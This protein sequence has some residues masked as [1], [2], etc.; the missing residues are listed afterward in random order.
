MTD[1]IPGKDGSRTHIKS[2][3]MRES[4]MDKSLLAST[5]AEGV[6]RML[7]DVNVVAIGGRSILDRG[8]AALVPLLDE[9]V[10]CRKRHKIVLG[11]G[12]GARTRHAYHIALDLGLPTGGLAMIAGAVNEQNRYMVQALLAKHGG[13]VLHKDHFIVLP[14]WLESGMIPIVSGMPPFHYWEPPAGLRRVPSHGEDFGLFMVAEAIGARTMTFVKDE[15][16]LYTADPKRDRSAEFIPAITAPEL[17]ARDLPDLIIERSVIEAMVHA[18]H[19]RR[20]QIINGL[21]PKLLRKA[22]KGEAVG[23]VITSD[24]DRRCSVESPSKAGREGHRWPVRAGNGT[25]PRRAE[26]PSRRPLA[27]ARL[28]DR[29]LLAGTDYGPPIRILPELNVIKFGG[30]SLMDRGRS[31]VFPLIEEIAEAAKRH[32]IL[33]G[34]GGGTRARHAYSV[35]LELGL[36]TGVLAAIGW[37]TSLQNAHMLQML[38]AKHGGVL[39][40]LMEDFD[41]L[42]LFLRTGCIPIRVGMPPYQHWEPP[43]ADGPHPGQP[44]RLGGLSHRRVPRG[45]LVHLPQGR[46][47]A[48]HRRPEEGPRGRVHPANQRRGADGDGPGRPRG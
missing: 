40:Q 27:R 21:K 10:R 46:A 24:P 14:L 20:I 31:A 4:L 48:L 7:P 5:E 3:L 42:P 16:G 18:R 38:L 36:P 35:A 17:L 22:L 15:D 43:P 30:Q 25:A 26:S 8:K 9:V 12:G 32:Q 28:S 34:A 41:K 33:I 11:V 37:P 39:L 2:P 47:G 29:E 6:L 1:I 23:T 44:H 13:V 45:P 19:V